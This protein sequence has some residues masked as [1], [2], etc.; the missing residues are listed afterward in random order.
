MRYY[1]VADVHGFYSDLVEA[2]TEKGFFADTGEKRLV[3]LGDLFDRGHEAEALQ[4]FALKT[5]QKGELIYI[6]GNHEDLMTELVDTL[7]LYG[8]SDIRYSHHMTNGTLGTLRQLARVNIAQLDYE[9][10]RVRM[11]MM[12]TP[13]FK[14]LLPITVDYLETDNYVF[15]HGWIPC[16]EIKVNAQDRFYTQ[17]NDWRGGD[18]ARARWLNGM[19]AHACG[20]RV[21]GKTVVCGHVTASYGHSVFEGKGE[22]YGDNADFSPYRA[23]GIIAID[24]CTAASKKINCLVIED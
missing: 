12:N 2:L 10:E 3:V 13:Y 16:K 14:R 5:A 20:V 1:V 17:I 22:L 11:R 4:D 15:V 8:G 19:A 24:A 7:D 21:E 6:R 23:D 18:W 9:P